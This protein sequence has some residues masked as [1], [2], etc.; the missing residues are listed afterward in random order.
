MDRCRPTEIRYMASRKRP[1]RTPLRRDP[2]ITFDASLAPDVLTGPDAR[3]IDLVRRM[4]LA[5]Q[6]LHDAMDALREAERRFA[7][8][9]ERLRRS[10]RQPDWLTTA[11][12]SEAAAMDQLDAIFREI[13]RT[14]ARSNIGL[15]IKVHLI[16][17]V[18]G[19]SADDAEN[20]DDM[21]LSL[22]ASV[23]RDLNRP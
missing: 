23:I 2:L 20:Q 12:D 7:S 1:S 11:Q 15:E 22:L 8:L 4:R 16:R 19:Q 3:L 17:I 6:A 9:P 10:T 13:A 14:P 18:Y 21:V 5:E